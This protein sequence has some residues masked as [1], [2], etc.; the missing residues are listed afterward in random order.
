MTPKLMLLRT[1]YCSF[2]GASGCWLLLLFLSARLFHS[3]GANA[4]TPTHS[5]RPIIRTS[6][7]S[8]MDSS[9]LRWEP[10]CAAKKLFGAQPSRVP[11]QS[12]HSHSPL[13]IIPRRML[14]E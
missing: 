11:G 14:S 5:P 2:L 3:I 7:R 4:I 10:V 1:S 13:I 6:A 12:Q 8:L 9:L